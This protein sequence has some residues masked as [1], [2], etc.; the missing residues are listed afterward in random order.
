MKLSLPPKAIVKIGANSPA[1]KSAEPANPSLLFSIFPI[2]PRN[3]IAI[4]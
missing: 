2:A 3:Y 4:H 1:T